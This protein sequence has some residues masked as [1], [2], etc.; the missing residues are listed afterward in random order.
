MNYI[1]IILQEVAKAG[2]YAILTVLGFVLFFAMYKF[3][4]N[5]F[6]SMMKISIETIE[7]SYK[8]ANASLNEYIEKYNKEFN[9]K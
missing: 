4:V 1:D 9:K 6:E 3:G 8:D 5:K 7:R 2:I